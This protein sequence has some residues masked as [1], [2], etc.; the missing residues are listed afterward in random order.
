MARVTLKRKPGDHEPMLTLAELTARVGL[1]VRTIRFYT[2]RGLVPAPLRRGRQGYYTDDH[3]AR[4]ELVR[5]LQAHG[6]TLSAIEGYLRSLPVDATPGDLALRRTML[7]P[8]Q[9]DSSVELTG[10][11]LD[12]RA[13]RTLTDDDRTAL[14]A[15]GIVTPLRRGRYRVALSQLSVGVS[16]LDLGFPVDAA[17]AAAKVYA[18]HGR[19]VAE[20]L[21]TLFRTMVWPR[22]RDKSTSPEQL[23]EI[24]EALK[25]LS[26]ASL[27]S[28][29]E[30]AMTEA[31]RDTIAK[32]AR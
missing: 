21:N 17:Q 5:E 10:V 16:L 24:V 22:F 27:V 30:A 2:A 29:Y 19:A 4:L 13:G 8:W 15:L 1:S 7:A 23:Q 9:A 31:R 3:V 11:E 12:D 32:R 25:P 28:A 26:V 6:F 18:A 14:E 20:E